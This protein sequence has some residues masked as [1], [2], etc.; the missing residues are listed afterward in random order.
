MDNFVK[1][2]GEDYTSYWIDG[3]SHPEGGFF[4]SYIDGSEYW[5]DDDGKRHRADG[6]AVIRGDGSKEWYNHGERVSESVA[7]GNNFRACI[8]NG[9]S[10]RWITL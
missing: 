9:I 1:T 5:Y 4:M 3:E 7:F 6:P 10:H 2:V 8:Q